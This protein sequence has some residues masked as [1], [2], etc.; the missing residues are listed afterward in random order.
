MVQSIDTAQRR[1]SL[2][3]TAV[4]EVDERENLKEYRQ[5]SSANE[6]AEKPMG[7]LGQLLSAKL[8]DLKKGDS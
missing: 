5:L 8:D 4:A 6:E 7:I 2:S 1:I 3:M